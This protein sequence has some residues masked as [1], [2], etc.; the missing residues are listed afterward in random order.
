MSGLIASMVGQDSTD[1]NGDYDGKENVAGS[2]CVGTSCCDDD[3][4]TRQ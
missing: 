3:D 4:L 2:L 1:V